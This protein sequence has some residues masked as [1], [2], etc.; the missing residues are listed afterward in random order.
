MNWRA[1]AAPMEGGARGD[2][3]KKRPVFLG[4]P[5]HG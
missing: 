2:T 4:E 3:P 1:D 5:D